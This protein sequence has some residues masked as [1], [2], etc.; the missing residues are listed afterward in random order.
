MIEP[1]PKNLRAG[2][3]GFD[4]REV[5][6][7]LAEAAAG[8][9]EEGTIA[10]LH[11]GHRRPEWGSRLLGFEKEILSHPRVEL[12]A[13][14]DCEGNPQMA[15]DT[16]RDFTWRYPRL[17]AWVALNDWPLQGRG[18]QILPLPA[19]CRLITFGGTPNQWPLLDSG[20]C[21][22][23]V[24]ANYGELGAKALRYCETALRQT[25]RYER[26]F[27]APLRTVWPT[28]LKEYQRDWA[29]WATGEYPPNEFSE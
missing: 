16:I 6:K 9:V 2:H 21:A 26:R 18:L 5:G 7:A 13:S 17:S 28:N 1:A 20:T 24:A 25:T 4:E 27:D 22:A 8:V 12:F 10:L 19:G 3:V 29:Y 23:V 15:R 14:R 11:A